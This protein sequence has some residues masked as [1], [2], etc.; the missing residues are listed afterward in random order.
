MRLRIASD[1]TGSSASDF[2]ALPQFRVRHK[3]ATAV[4]SAATRRKMVINDNNRS[5]HNLEQPQAPRIGA[6]RWLRRQGYLISTGEPKRHPFWGVSAVGVGSFG[7]GQSSR[8]FCGSLRCS[9][10]SLE[11]TLQVGPRAAQWLY[12]VV[13]KG[14]EAPPP[15][16]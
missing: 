15:P 3:Q 2:L 5:R 12:F 13:S 11:G 14:A 16:L 6:L 1:I 7:L 10:L 4:A 8:S 9:I